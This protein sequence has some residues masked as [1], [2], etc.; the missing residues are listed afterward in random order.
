MM[1]RHGELIGLVFFLAVVAAMIRY[2]LIL[3]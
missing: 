2:G 1:E 3:P